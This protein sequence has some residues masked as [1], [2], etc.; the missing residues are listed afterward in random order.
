VKARLHLQFSSSDGCERVD[1]TMSY[2]H[3]RMH[4]GTYTHMPSHSL[5][6]LLQ[7]DIVLSVE[8]EFRSNASVF[9]KYIQYRILSNI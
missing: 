8:I 7:V 1:G 3:A 9:P 6:T 4:E 5:Y 2:R